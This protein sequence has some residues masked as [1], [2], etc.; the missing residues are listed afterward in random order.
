M[1]FT[2][3]N[4]ISISSK[5]VVTVEGKENKN[6]NYQYIVWMDLKD[7]FGGIKHNV[8]SV[9]LLQHPG[10]NGSP[11]HVLVQELFNESEGGSLENKH[12]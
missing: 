4:K 6:I 7:A 10:G 5:E 1:R 3:Q 9:T 8:C 11:P 12:I 2:E